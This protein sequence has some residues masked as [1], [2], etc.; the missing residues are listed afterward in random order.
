M[1][2][3]IAANWKQNGD[4]KSL[5]KLTREIKFNLAKLKLNHTVIIFPPLIYTSEI[6]NLLKKDK[7]SRNNIKLGVQNISPY[8]NG[9]YTGEIS[10]DMLNDFNC[11]YVLLGHSERRHI[12]MESDDLISSKFHKSITNNKKT[13]LCVGETLK[14]YNM[15][16]TNSIISRQLRNAFKNSI[17]LISKNKRNLIIA[18]EPVWAIGTGKAASIV[19]IEITHKFIRKC[20]NNLIG[21][22]HLDIKIL[23]GGSVSP[24]NASEILNIEGVDGALVGGASLVSKKFIDICRAI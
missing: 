11:S 1:K 10:V 4:L 17:K 3:I 24:N 14:E 2:K 19:D 5:S 16:K 12:F 7:K 13:I 8:N 6:Y 15:K 18:Y 9:P 21:D 22:P 23:Y 20:L